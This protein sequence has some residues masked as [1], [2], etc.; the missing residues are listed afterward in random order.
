MFPALLAGNTILIEPAED[1]PLS[2]LYITR[3]AQE[4][5]FPPGVI[6]VLPGRGELTDAP[7]PSIQGFALCPLRA[8]NARMPSHFPSKLYSGE[9]NVAAGTAACGASS[10]GRL[11]G[12]LGLA[13]TREIGN[14]QEAASA[15]G[16]TME[17]VSQTGTRA[18]APPM[19]ST[20]SPG[21][22]LIFGHKAPLDDRPPRPAASSAHYTAGRDQTDSS[23]GISRSTLM[24]RGPRAPCSP[25]GRFFVSRPGRRSEPG[26]K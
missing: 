12:Q 25:S 5:G 16:Y 17:A 7:S 20:R 19:M 23:R 22:K 1:T 24:S 8:A 4:G 18:S 14:Q 3:L 6:I 13:S 2:A 11:P 10:P 21:T 15:G 26:T 9:S